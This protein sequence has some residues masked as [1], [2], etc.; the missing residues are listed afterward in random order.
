MRR[1]GGVRP[2]IRLRI[3]SSARGKGSGDAWGIAVR[4][5]LGGS[6]TSPV[7]KL[8]EEQRRENQKKWKRRAGYGRRWVVE[9]VFSAFKRIFG[10]CVRSVKWEDIVHEIMLKVATY[11]MITARGGWNV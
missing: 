7:G 4:E 3:N 9:I 6:P 2:L 11:N 10:E 5:Q 1:Q 8:T